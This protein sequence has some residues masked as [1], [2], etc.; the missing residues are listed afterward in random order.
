M[1]VKYLKIKT[2][3]QNKIIGFDTGPGNY[4]IDK[5]VKTNSKMEFDDGGLLAKSGQSNEDIL[6]KFIKKSLIILYFCNRLLQ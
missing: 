1:Q 5:W 6:K 2:K 4:L 3:N